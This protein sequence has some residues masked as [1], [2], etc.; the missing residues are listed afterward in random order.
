MWKQFLSFWKIKTPNLNLKVS[1]RTV[2]STYTQHQSIF[3]IAVLPVAFLATIHAILQIDNFFV[4]FL[5]RASFV[6]TIL[7]TYQHHRS[8][9]LIVIPFLTITQTTILSFK[10]TH[11]LCLK[12]TTSP[13][14]KTKI[15]NAIILDFYTP[16]LFFPP[17]LSWKKT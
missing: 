7:R 2:T 10:E 9:N 11:P 5:H 17:S 8:H 16:I 6:N 14:S 3:E 1:Y 12:T 15:K 13:K 4:A